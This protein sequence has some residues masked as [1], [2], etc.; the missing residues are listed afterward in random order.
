MQFD[1]MDWSRGGGYSLWATA[2]IYAI[3]AEVGGNFPYR[4]HKM[5]LLQIT[6]QTT[7]K[8]YAIA[9]NN[10]ANLHLQH[11]HRDR[12]RFGRFFNLRSR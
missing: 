1:P 12:G 10:C 9:A 6:V 11:K 3:E 7:A 4:F 8:Y 5:R 2:R